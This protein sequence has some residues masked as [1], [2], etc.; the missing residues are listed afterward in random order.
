MFFLLFQRNLLWTSTPHTWFLSQN[1]CYWHVDFCMLT[2]KSPTLLKFF[3]C[4][5]TCV[6]LFSLLSRGGPRCVQWRII[7]LPF[8]FV[9][10]FCL[11][12]LL[13][14]ESGYWSHPL[15]L[16]LNLPVLLRPTVLASWDQVHQCLHLYSY[17]HHILL[18]NSS[19]VNYSDVISSN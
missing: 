17:N 19:L 9:Y 16:C 1:A 11:N 13:I 15:L 7:W 18:I 14:D 3:T 5:Q 12:D 8:S 10:F 2:L 6:N 4:L